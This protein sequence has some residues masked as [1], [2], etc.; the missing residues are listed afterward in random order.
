MTRGSNPYLKALARPGALRFSAAAFVGRMQI[1][2]F[3]L[4]TVLLISSLTG[5]YG[6]AGTVTAAGAASY[7][8]VS[9]LVAR[10]ADRFGQ[11]AVLRP[12]TLVYSA[13]T[14]ATAAM[15]DGYN[16]AMG[17]ADITAAMDGFAGNWSIHRARLTASMRGLQ[18]KVHRT[19][20][21]ISRTDD[22]LSQQLASRTK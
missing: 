7:A 9:P 18:Q 13:A 14:A 6:L 19:H 21:E 22:D 5:R 15:Q 8:F 3:G 2:M 4:G 16:G 12:L 11:R 1:S 10:L 17:S 20:R